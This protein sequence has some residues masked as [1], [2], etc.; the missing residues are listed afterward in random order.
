V[1]DLRRHF[2]GVHAVDGASFT[3]RRGSVTALIG[4]NGAGK[5]TAF[6][7][8]T[9]FARPDGGRVVFDGRDVTGVRADRLAR[10][11]M[12]RT[13][14]LTRVLGK[15]TVLDNVMLAGGEQPGERF[16]TAAFRRGRWSSRET[17]LRERAEGVLEDIGL[18]PLRDAYAATLSGGQ[19]K[20][21]ELGRALMAE[22]RLILLDE[23]M[24]GVNPTLG[25]RLL[26]MLDGLRHDRGL[27]ILFIEHD[28]EV[29]M[30]RSDE[31]IVMGEGRVVLQDAPDVVRRDTRVIDAY[32]GGGLPGE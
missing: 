9:G 23:P 7:L 17:D 26:E 19:R 24:A 11:G 12:V 20:L 5:T 29:V 10:L 2:G 31:V 18:L 15:M 21:L 8:M 6:N 1:R 22:P 28:M 14:Q 30:G 13:F 32:L 3:V 27:T 4:P 16:L 25:R